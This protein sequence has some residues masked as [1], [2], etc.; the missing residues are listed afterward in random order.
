MALI[1]AAFIPENPVS[2]AFKK[3]GSSL[4]YELKKDPGELNS[5]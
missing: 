2:T 5:L 4:S 3:A 1:V